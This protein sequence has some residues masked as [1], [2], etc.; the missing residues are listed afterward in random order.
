MKFAPC[1]EKGFADI[2]IVEAL[3]KRDSGDPD[4]LIDLVES[5]RKVVMESLGD[6]AA[7]KL[8]GLDEE[9]AQIKARPSKGSSKAKPKGASSSTARSVSSTAAKADPATDRLAP[10]HNEETAPNAAMPSGGKSTADDLPDFAQ[11]V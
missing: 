5:A 4:R 10:A 11:G 8:R 2:Q 9:L 1:F 6:A 3:K 7:V